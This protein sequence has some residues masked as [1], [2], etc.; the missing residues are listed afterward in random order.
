MSN[1]PVL[2]LDRASIVAEL[3][4]APPHLEVVETV[5]STNN[6]LKQQLPQLPSPSVLIA[7]EQ[8]A[9]RGR[10]GRAW[11]SPANQGLYLSMAVQLDMPLTPLSALSLV[12]GLAA[13]QAIEACSGAA[14]QLKWPNDL[15]LDGCKCGGCLVEVI[16]EATQPS[17]LPWAIIGVGI[18]LQLADDLGIDQAWTDLGRAGHAINI[19]PLA[20]E[21]ITQLRH[22][23]AVFGQSGF[24]GL[25]PQWQARDA[26]Y[27]QAVVVEQGPNPSVHGRAAGVTD[28][29][30]LRLITAA[31]EQHISSGEVS[32]RRA[33]G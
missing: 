10:R 4:D 2:T 14:L 18:N 24:A 8:T 11:H 7:S 31:G 33:K 26:F 20:A 12:T 15:W 29:G 5:D 23:V 3:K 27:G 9:G 17:A 25:R 32:L 28:T 6:R 21:L 22:H 16:S 30:A 19:N 1:L 13:A